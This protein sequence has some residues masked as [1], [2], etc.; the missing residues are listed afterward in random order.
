MQAIRAV[1]PEDAS[2]ARPLDEVMRSRYA[3][4]FAE[5]RQRVAVAWRRAGATWTE[6]IA[7]EDPALGVRR[8]I[9]ASSGGLVA[10]AR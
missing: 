10:G 2:I 6:V 1:D 7:D 8:V 4:N 5:W 3:S 9:G